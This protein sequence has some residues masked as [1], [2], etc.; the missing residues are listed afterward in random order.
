MKRKILFL[1]HSA[2]LYG[3]EKVLFQTIDGLNKQEF[4]PILV[5][6]RTGPLRG[7]AEKLAVETVLVPSK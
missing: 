3:A 2:E 1:S 6:P 4:Q 7:E 5:L